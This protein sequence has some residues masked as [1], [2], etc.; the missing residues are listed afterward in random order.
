MLRRW[1]RAA[2]ASYERPWLR[3]ALHFA[4]AS[5][6]LLWTLLRLR[7]RLR[8]D[9]LKAAIDEAAAAR[10]GLRKAM[11]RLSDWDQ[12]MRAC[13]EDDV[14]CW[15]LLAFRVRALCL[16]R[17]L[18]MIDRL[19]RLPRTETLELVI[20]AQRVRGGIDAHSWIVANGV[21]FRQDPS[22][23]RGLSVLSRFPHRFAAVGDGRPAG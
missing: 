8:R 4:T 3:S 13:H 21:D 12:Q 16:Y 5:P 20:G 11:L 10:L 14:I 9:G 15:W 6:V 19:S 1:R 22:E 7:R 2:P 17:C 23:W 18:V